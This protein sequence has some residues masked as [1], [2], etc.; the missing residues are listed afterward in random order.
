MDQSALATADDMW[1]GIGTERGT[2]KGSGLVQPD[3]FEDIPGTSTV[4]G[5]SSNTPDRSR[6]VAKMNEETVVVSQ[7]TVVIS[8]IVVS[9]LFATTK[10]IS[11]F[12]EG[13][14]PATD[15]PLFQE[16]ITA[17]DA[18]S[19]SAVLT[20]E[21]NGFRL[22]GP[23]GKALFVLV[24][25]TGGFTAGSVMVSGHYEQGLRDAPRS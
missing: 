12:H 3:F 7:N 5:F 16:A 14:D 8:L 15:A 6:R 19:R 13:Q 11:I 22:V 9:T 23:P 2:I 21:A 1:V 4:S 17:N 10:V 24:S 25:G 18:T 20:G